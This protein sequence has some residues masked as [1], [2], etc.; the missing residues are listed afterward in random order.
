VLD[1]ARRVLRSC[2]ALAFSLLLVGCG[3]APSSGDLATRA[4]ETIELVF[5]GD[6]AAV[7]AEFDETLSASLSEEQLAESRAQFEDQFGTFQSMGE[8]EVLER[9][10]LTVV[11]VPLD[12]SEGEGEARVTYDAEGKITGLFLLR[13][14]VPVP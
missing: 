6:Y 10:E 12:M 11:N 3:G 9:G 13:P 14:G 2:C 8:P 7:R 4:T 5:A 1:T